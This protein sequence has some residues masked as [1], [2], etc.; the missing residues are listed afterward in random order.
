MKK[1]QIIPGLLLIIMLQLSACS[2]LIEIDS[3]KNQLTTDKVFADT[4]SAKSALFNIY[5]ALENQ[6]YNTSN[7]YLSVYTDESISSSSE[8]WNQS[9]LSSTEGTMRSNW[10]SLYN[11][12]YQSNMILERLDIASSLPEA[13]KN[14]INAEARFLRAYCYFYL[15]NLYGSIPLITTTNVDANR[16]ARQVAQAKIYEQIISDLSAARSDLSLTYQGTGKIRA[17]KACATAL[18][19]RVYLYQSNWT[20]A[21]NMAD[22]LI[23]SGTYTPLEAPANVFRAGSRESILQFATA[24]GFVTESG[25][26]VPASAT[27]SP[28]F[29]FTD[30]FYLSFENTDLRKTSWIGTNTTT[31]GGVTTIYRYPAK[32]KNRVA[33]TAKPENLVVLRIAEQYLIRAEAR[34]QQGKLTGTN[35]AV[36]DLNVIRSRAGLGNISPSTLATVL[37]AIY[38]E[39][40]HEMFFENSDRFIDLKRS[41][42]LQA[43]MALAKPTWIPECAVLPIPAGEITTNSKL[44]QNEGY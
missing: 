40:R 14:K 9:R 27:V 1:N 3:P 28:L 34:A 30:Q 43:V 39:R 29:F 5:L 12:I 33:N 32:Y 17:N 22:E 41:G 38:T 37:E 16:Q 23:G 15:V 24:N 13:F 6:H 19:A 42:N 4:T 25:S 11:C 10:S 2:K 36:S 35:S 8:P 44:V 20:L 7:R 21:E 26:A 31:S 18:L